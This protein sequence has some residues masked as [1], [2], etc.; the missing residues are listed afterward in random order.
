MLCG[1]EG[2]VPNGLHGPDPR[3]LGRRLAYAG[4]ADPKTRLAVAQALPNAVSS[5]PQADAVAELV[6]L[7]P[8]GLRGR[9]SQYSVQT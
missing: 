5:P 4:N 7:M 6:A 3:G 9:A 8:K 2:A 1:P